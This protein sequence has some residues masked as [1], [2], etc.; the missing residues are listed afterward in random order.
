MMHQGSGTEPVRAHVKSG[1]IF[2]ER[3]LP[4]CF[5]TSGIGFC[6]EAVHARAPIAFTACMIVSAQGLDHPQRR[7]RQVHHK[8]QAEQAGRLTFFEADAVELQ[9]V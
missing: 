3:V 9:T 2:G 6:I 7:A 8:Q 4:A 5:N 1:W